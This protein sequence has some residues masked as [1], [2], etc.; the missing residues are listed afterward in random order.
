MALDRTGTSARKSFS[1]L[2]RQQAACYPVCYS[3]AAGIPSHALHASSNS[4]WGRELSTSWA[5]THTGIGDP[6]I[7]RPYSPHLVVEGYAVDING[8]MVDIKG[9]TGY[10][11][12]SDEG[13]G[14]PTVD[15]A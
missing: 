8:C 12:L 4:C 7:P 5:R 11:Q 10:T 14:R 15:S 2:D 1:R 6:V 3:R 9:Q 13:R